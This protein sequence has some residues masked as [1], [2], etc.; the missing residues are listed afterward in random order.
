MKDSRIGENQLT[1]LNLDEL[2]KCLF[3]KSGSQMAIQRF[4]KCRGPKA[5][6][7]RS[8]WRRDKPPYIYILTNKVNY[9]DKVKNQ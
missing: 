9:H 1:L 4:I 8:V 2:E 5:F 7:C 3:S 6:V